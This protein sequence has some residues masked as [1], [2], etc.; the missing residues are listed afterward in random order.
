MVRKRATP[1]FRKSQII[2]AADLVLLEM[3]I[4][5]FTIDRVIDRAKIAKGTVYNYYK[6]KDEMLADL[7]Y[8]ALSM[9]LSHFHTAVGGQKSSVEKVKAI[10]KSS[11]DYYRVYPQYFELISYMERPDFEINMS[12]YLKL[13]QEITNMVNHVVA[14][15][16]EKGEIKKDLSSD[17]ITYIIWACSVGVVQFVES[18]EKLLKN[19]HEIS[20][21]Q[22]IKG[23]SEM[24]TKGISL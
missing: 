4:E 17:M 8:K 14:E 24:I 21:Q 10:C 9:L 2:A 1:E 13:S 5:H 16:Q 15:G 7:G 22:M 23:F 19:H 11:Y 3:G 6:N 20:T 18:K 12:N